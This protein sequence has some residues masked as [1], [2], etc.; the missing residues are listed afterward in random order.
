MIHPAKTISFDAL[1]KG[2]NEYVAKSYINRQDQD[3]LSLFNYS[4]NCQ[5]E[6]VWNIF[7]T[8][9]RGLVLDIPNKKI[10]ALGLPK[11]MNVGEPGNMLHELPLEPFT[12]WQKIDG[13]CV[14]VYYYK[15]SWKCCT[16]GSFNSE[17]AKWAQEIID[18]NNPKL[19]KKYSY[20]FEL[21][22]PENRIVVKYDTIELILLT[23]FDLS[24]G[25]EIEYDLASSFIT[26]QSS[27][28]NKLDRLPYTKIDDILIYCTTSDKN[29]EGFVVQFDGGLRVK[30]KTDK[31]K[32]LHRL[33]SDISPKRIWE[34]IVKG[35]DKGE[36]ISS[37][38][39]EFHEEV[40]EYW[41]NIISN[42]NQTTNTVNQI[43][44]K[45]K[46]FP[47]R[48]EFALY[49]KEYYHELIGFL[50]MKLDNTDINQIKLA[51]LKTLKPKDSR[52]FGWSNDIIPVDID[53]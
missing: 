17:Q 15:G 29:E 13:S 32:T 18:N 19:N 44:E 50:F 47:T 27:Q 46:D 52:K 33:I 38:P 8:S 10:I 14:M 45:I 51:I 41:D 9:S 34:N 28:F 12:I 26:T 3:G 35:T 43:F 11:F 20:V 40:S 42:L 2:L 6:R 48:K 31:Y 22:Y 21:I 1:L 4:P 39:D 37:L 25:E 24:T 5:F 53:E 23:A 16:R 30:V 49:T 7:T 36:V